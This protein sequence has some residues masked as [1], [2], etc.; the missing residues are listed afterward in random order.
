MDAT[1]AGMH[2]RLRRYMRDTVEVLARTATY[3]R[4][5]N[6]TVSD[7]VTAVAPAQWADVTASER[8]GA[9]TQQAGADI[10]AARCKIVTDATLAGALAPNVLVRR[11][12]DPTVWRVLWVSAPTLAGAINVYVTADTDVRTVV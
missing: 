1:L 8:A 5:G 7:V 4:Y 9:T 2:R 11:G 12:G 6:A 10:S 3:D